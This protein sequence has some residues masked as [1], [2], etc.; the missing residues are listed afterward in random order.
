MYEWIK[1][2]C[3][4]EYSAKQERFELGRLTG[5][6]KN[7]LTMDKPPSGMTVLGQYF[8]ASS[9]LDDES[10]AQV[11]P[12]QDEEF[13]AILMEQVAPHFK[14][15]RE[16]G[17]EG[18]IESLFLEQL[19]PESKILFEETKTGILPVIQ[20]LY[21]HKDM[22]SHYHGGKRQL[23]HYPVNLKLLKPYDAPDVQELKTLLRKFYFKSGGESSLMPVGW[24]FEDSLRDSALLRFLAGFVPHVTMLV[25]ADSNEVVLLRMGENEL[26]HTLE[27][28]SA[29]PQPPRR[30]NNYLYLDMG[31][32]LVFVV[33]LAGQPPVE[34]WNDLR[35]K[36][37]YYLPEDSDFAD[38]D[39]ETAA[40]IPEGIGLF[41]DSDF[42]KAMVEAVNR[43][44]RLINA[45]GGK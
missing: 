1:D 42:T 40:P 2:R 33:D 43:E 37:G 39:H 7:R 30:H 44:L 38:F 12:V 14:V 28:N 20:D 25:D 41:F 26:S 5:F 45:L 24:M 16:A 22:S 8:I 23:I 36:Q 31:I 21:R 18:V 19:R 9:V 3:L 27:L 35:A 10:F 29:K 32:G 15:V 34:D 17:H 6:Y 11:I 4:L 13:R